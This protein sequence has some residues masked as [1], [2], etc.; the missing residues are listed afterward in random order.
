ML[1]Q[2]LRPGGDSLPAGCHCHFYTETHPSE[3]FLCLT[4]SYKLL[5][6]EINQFGRRAIIPLHG[7]GEK[8]SNRLMLKKKKALINGKF[9]A[10]GM[11]SKQF[12]FYFNKVTLKITP[13]FFLNSK[14]EKSF[15]LFPAIKISPNVR[16]M[17]SKWLAGCSVGC[18]VTFSPKLMLWTWS[19]S[20]AKDQGKEQSSESRVL[21]LPLISVSLNSKTVNGSYWPKFQG[22]HKIGLQWKERAPFN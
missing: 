21:Q 4:L 6:T 12:D 5:W 19:S 7:K 22:C 1:G 10:F 3:G 8:I 14:N 20:S 17:D 9:T 15:Q 11:P 16:W 18:P 2:C 13:N